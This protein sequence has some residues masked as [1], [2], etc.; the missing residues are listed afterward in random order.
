[1][2]EESKTAPLHHKND[3]KV[4]DPFR[5]LIDLSQEV[6]K[7]GSCVCYTPQESPSIV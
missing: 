3:F 7:I 2:L 1:M 5:A 6:G 4:F